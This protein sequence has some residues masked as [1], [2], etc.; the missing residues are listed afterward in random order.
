MDIDPHMDEQ[1]E[2]LIQRHYYS[3]EFEL[4]GALH[5]W[6]IELDDAQKA[7]LDRVFSARLHRDASILN[8]SLCHCFPLPGV[9]RALVAEMERHQAPN[10]TTRAL[11]AV[12]ARYSS[13]ESAV[14][15]ERF[16]DSSQEMEALRALAAI[17]FRRAVPHI[18]RAIRKDAMVETCLHILWEHRKRVGFE[19]FL[20]D[21]RPLRGKDPQWMS[22]RFASIF[23][24]KSQDKIPFPSEEQE[25]MLRFFRDGAP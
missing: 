11:L 21:I 9:E 16:I 6:I 12:L 10:H 8:I 15:V 2:A 22:R 17:D 7:A 20:D 3:E 1:L 24:I 14:A 4:H 19:T 5:A 18:Q 13:P 25:H 23:T